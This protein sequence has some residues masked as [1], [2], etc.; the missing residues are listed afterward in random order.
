MPKRMKFHDLEHTLSVT[1]MA[2]GIGQAV[3]LDREELLLLEVAALFHDTGYAL[4]HV[5]HEEK[6]A[7]LAAAFLAKQGVAKRTIKR[8]QA[9]ILATRT[10]VAPHGAL[11]RVLRDADSSKAGQT[12][13]GEKSERLRQE[14]E[15]VH[16]AG[17]MP[18]I[19]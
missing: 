14:L 4:A 7:G 8:V 18:T 6:S 13:F 1:R 12:D 5:G 17:S 9:L 3:K 16:G 15:L 2:V 10:S 11:Q 19:G